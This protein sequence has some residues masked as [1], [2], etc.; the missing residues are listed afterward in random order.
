MLPVSVIIPARNEAGN[1]ARLIDSLLR[2]TEPPGE[3]I[4]VDAGST[5]GTGEIARQMGCRVIRVDRAYPGQARNV[6]VRHAQ[7]DLVAFWDGSMWLAP[8]CLALLVSPLLEY[9]ADLVL[10]NLR[11][12]PQSWA[13]FLNHLFLQLPYSEWR[14]SQPFYTPPV[15][16]SALRRSLWER[17][18]GFPPWRAREDSE[19]RR[20]LMALG[21]RIYI[22]P[23]A[24]TY[25]EPAETWHSLVKKVR[26]YGRHNLLS[27]KPWEWYGGLFRVYGGYGVIIMLVG[28]MGGGWLGMLGTAAGVISAGSVFRALRKALKSLRYFR[29]LKYPRPL[30]FRTLMEGT[31]LL[32]ATDWA[33]FAGLWDWFWKDWLG[34]DPETFPEPVIEAAPTSDI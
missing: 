30:T 16:G 10:G 23:A 4:V 2:Q 3:I 14:E 33:S 22:E 24:I 6:G 21:P 7:Y 20:R 18:G 32:L 34:L 27:G 17:A 8:D 5:D 12:L 28:A 29:Y 1:I 15:V 26:L 19:F 11:T 13:S 25:W 9:K 31:A